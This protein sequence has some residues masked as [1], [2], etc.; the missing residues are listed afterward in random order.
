MKPLTFLKAIGDNVRL[1]R[2]KKKLSQEKLAE[3]SNLH[4]TFVSNL[5][6]GKLNVSILSYYQI[7]K[8]LET[9]LAKLFILKPAKVAKRTK[10]KLP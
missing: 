9:P 1:I 8:A 10:K 3:L 5:E 4:P 6:N 7:A 2:T